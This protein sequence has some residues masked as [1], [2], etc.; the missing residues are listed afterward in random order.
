MENSG[1]E[2]TVLLLDRVWAL[3]WNDW[4]WEDA[5]G[6]CHWLIFSAISAITTA[7]WCRFSSFVSRYPSL[8]LQSSILL[9][10]AFR[11]FCEVVAC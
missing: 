4:N 2:Q 6:L 10:L 9:D 5:D 1:L 8:F 3:I 7:C 11:Q